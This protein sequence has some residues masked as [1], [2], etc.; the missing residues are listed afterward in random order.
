MCRWKKKV[1]CQNGEPVSRASAYRNQYLHNDVVDWNMDQLNEKSNE[2][3]DAKADGSC[4]GDLL[5]FCCN[6]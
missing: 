5:E 3:H 6:E 2:A 4:H 1:S